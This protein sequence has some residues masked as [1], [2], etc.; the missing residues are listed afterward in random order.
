MSCRNRR[1]PG[2]VEM[3][4][5]RIRDSSLLNV[6]G[7][8]GVVNKLQ[9]PQLIIFDLDGTLIDTA[10]DLVYATKVML[11]QLGYRP[12]DEAHMTGWIG[13][14][15][16]M[17][18]K[19]ALTGEMNPS[20]TPDDFDQ[21]FTIFAKAYADNVFNRST[22]YPGVI[23]GLEQLKDNNF[24]L[25][26]ITNKLSRFT[27]PLME[28]S[29]LA[30][31]FDFV[32]SGDEFDQ[33]KPHPLPLISTARRFNVDPLKSLMVGDSQNDVGAGRAAGFYVVCVSYGYLNGGRV[34]DLKADLVIDSLAD[35]PQYLLQV[36]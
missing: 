34:D 11:D 6:G 7:D 18:I 36:N 2:S 8:Q 13:N 29:G 25:A 4:F 9:N 26:C 3:D 32:G 33:L 10:P 17:L 1:D 30:G 23:D 22:I 27:Q 15:I 31:Y 16:S 24:N 20:H 5:R 19:R 12:I 21:A 28:Q 14:G 35:L